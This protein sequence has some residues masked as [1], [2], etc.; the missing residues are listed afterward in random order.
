MGS[1]RQSRGQAGGWGVWPLHAQR[2]AVCSGLQRRR[3]I[4]APMPDTAALGRKPSLPGQWVDLPPPLAGTLKEPFEIKV[5]EI[6]DVERLQRRRVPP[7]EGP[8]EV[9]T[10]GVWLGG[11]GGFSVLLAARQ[12]HLP[13]LSAALPELGKGR[14]S[15]AGPEP[16]AVEG[17]LWPP[18]LCPGIALGWGGPSHSYGAHPGPGFQE[19]LGAHGLSPTGVGSGAVREGQ[20]LTT[21]HLGSPTVR[22]SRPGVWNRARVKAGV[23][24]P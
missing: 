9:G 11:Q 2:P 6:D 14:N 18:P 1:A 15:P 23:P 12:P 4:Q 7:R 16:L 13:L 5:Y 22:L 19:A 20:G 24:E 21:A 3:L 8:A 17:V 10:A